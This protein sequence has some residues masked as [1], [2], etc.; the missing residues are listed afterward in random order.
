MSVSSMVRKA[1][2]AVERARKEHAVY[3]AQIAGLRRGLPKDRE[4]GRA[5]LLPCV[6]SFYGVRV[7]DGQ[8]KAEGQKVLD[9]DAGGY[10][11][12]KTALRR[13]VNDIYGS[14]ESGSADVVAQALRLV[15]KMTAAQKRKFI[16]AL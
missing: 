11:A 14:N 12:A 15:A 10:E 2:G 16:A 8:G 5:V 6:A 9:S 4:K 3:E 7:V 1:L 13:M